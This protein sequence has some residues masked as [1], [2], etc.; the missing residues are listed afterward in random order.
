MVS[1]YDQQWAFPRT[2]VAGPGEDDIQSTV[3]ACKE[4]GL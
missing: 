3:G 2:G 4:E 1:T